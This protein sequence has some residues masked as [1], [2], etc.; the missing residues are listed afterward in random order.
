MTATLPSLNQFWRML[1]NHDWTFDYSDDHS[2]WR[3]GTAELSAIREVVEA[4]GEEYKKLFDEYSAYA[5]RKDNSIEQPKRP[6]R[7]REDQ[8]HDRQ[9]INNLAEALCH[10]RDEM[11]TL[12]EEQIISATQLWG[13]YS[14]IQGMISQISNLVEEKS[15]SPMWNTV[16]YKGYRRIKEDVDRYS[17]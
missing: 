12:E 9:L 3:R 16:A 10:L 11:W 8:E 5:W 2:I 13:L 14:P 7:S 17:K 15:N 1:R 6:A 4:G